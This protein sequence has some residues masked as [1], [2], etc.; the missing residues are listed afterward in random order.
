MRIFVGNLASTTTED[1]LRQLFAPYG[2][3]EYASI[4]ADQ[5]TGQAQGFVGMPDATAAQAAIDGLQGTRLEGRTW[6]IHA[7]RWQW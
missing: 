4:I 3:I 1:Q 2:E 7:A 5:A 6:T